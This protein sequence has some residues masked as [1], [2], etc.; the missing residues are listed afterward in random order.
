MTTVAGCVAALQKADTAAADHD[1]FEAAD[2]I[3]TAVGCTRTIQRAEQLARFANLAMKRV[4]EEACELR[5]EAGGDG[6]CQ[7]AHICMEA[8]LVPPAK[9]LATGCAGGP[10]HAC[11]G[12]QALPA[13][14]RRC[15]GLCDAANGAATIT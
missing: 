1:T 9:L 10:A 3:D 11:V 8:G 14:G 6:A 12:L 15:A 4:R 2:D 7:E 13:S 5:W